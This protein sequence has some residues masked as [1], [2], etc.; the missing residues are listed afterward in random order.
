VVG[1]PSEEGGVGREK[2]TRL[3]HTF[4]GGEVNIEIKNFLY[5]GGGTM[6]W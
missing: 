1:V 4:M 3:I 5:H 6:V 2:P